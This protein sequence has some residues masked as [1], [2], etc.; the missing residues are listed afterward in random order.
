MIPL[1]QV[2]AIGRTDLEIAPRESDT[3]SGPVP[4][5]VLTSERSARAD[6][7]EISIVPADSRAVVSRYSEAIETVRALAQELRVDGWFTSD[8]THYA[9]V[10]S[11]RSRLVR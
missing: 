8:Q 9:R 4:G 11:Y 10:A 1:A 5:D 7:Y 2:P 6:V 3:G